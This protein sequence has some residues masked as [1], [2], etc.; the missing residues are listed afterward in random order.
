MAQASS[1][2]VSENG[3]ASS[4]SSGELL[5]VQFNQDNTCFA[6]GTTNGFVIYFVDPLK[7]TFRRIFS[8]GGIGLVEMLYRC[9]L[10]AIV[11]GGRSPRYPTN[12][13]MIWDDIQNTSI[14]ELIFK[15]EVYAVRLRRDRVVVVLLNKVYVY[16]FKN[17]KMLHS[18]QTI[19]N[20]RGLVALCSDTANNVLAFPGQNKGSIRVELFHLSKTTC[21]KAHDTDLAQFALTY[22]GSRIAS[23]S[24]KGTLIRVWDCVTGDLLRELRRGMDR[25]DIYCIAFNFGGNKLACSSDKGTVHIFSFSNSNSI[26]TSSNSSNGG[27]PSNSAGNGDSV[28]ESSSFSSTNN[29]NNT[30]NSNFNATGTSS[31][32]SSNNFGFWRGVLPTSLVPKY[33]DSEW[34]NAQVHGISGK[35]LVAFSRDSSKIF[36]VSLEGVFMSCSC[37]ESGECPRLSTIKFIQS[38]MENSDVSSNYSS[39]NSNSNATTNL[40]TNAM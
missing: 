25:A 33:F 16:H 1:Q 36:I 11:G 8:N 35:S 9:N 34:S 18:Y 27:T 32:K 28:E 10:L 38:E 26:Q 13:V 30:N 40:Y 20:P 22:D 5:S 14:G 4:T 2:R 29:S 17:L 7:E 21:L 37:V 24:E 39:N 3:S 6:C 31:G 23:A 19:N 12:K 15:S